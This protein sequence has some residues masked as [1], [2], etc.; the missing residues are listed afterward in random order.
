MGISQNRLDVFDLL[1]TPIPRL[2]PQLRI[3][4]QTIWKRDP[5]PGGEILRNNKC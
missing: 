5:C 3:K 4:R 1:L 2:L